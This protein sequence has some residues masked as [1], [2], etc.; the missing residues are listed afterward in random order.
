M[1]ISAIQRWRIRRL[2]N[3]GE[4]KNAHDLAEKELGRKNHHFATDIIVRSMYNLSRWEDVIAFAKKHPEAD[5]N[6]YVYKSH[7][8]VSERIEAAEGVPKPISTQVWN[9]VDLL[10]NWVQEG[11]RLWLKHPW[12]WVH[13]D[14]PNGFELSKT[15]PALLHLAL[16]VL[17]S[18]WVKKT[19]KWNVW[20]EGNQESI[21]HSLIPEASILLQPCF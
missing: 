5:T 14:M 3:A 9:E 17:L 2:Y 1:L 19:K 15:H 7:Q 6:G 8:R 4:W 10:E 12:G 20:R 21:T 16:E 13:W 11:S 18:P